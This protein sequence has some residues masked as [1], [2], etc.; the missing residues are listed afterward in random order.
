MESNLKLIL[1]SATTSG[2]VE[3][4]GFE[5]I[6]LKKS[7]A[8][9]TDLSKRK[10]AYTLNFTVGG[11]ENNNKLFNHIFEIGADSTFDSRKKAK[12]WLLQDS[13][14]II[15]GV[16]QLVNISVDAQQKII[17]ELTISDEAKDL[18]LEIGEGYI[19]DLDYSSLAHTLSFSAVTNS[20]T[21]G[22]DYFYPLVDY[23]YDLA[24]NDING[25]NNVSGMTLNK[26]FPA[27]SVK[28]IFD[29]IISET[30]KSIKS[31]FLTG[32][33]FA[34]LFIPFNGDASGNLSEDFITQ[35][36]YKATAPTE[37]LVNYT[38]VT[39]VFFSG[40][41][42]FV[43][44]YSVR[45]PATNDSTGGN[46]DGGGLYDNVN[47]IYTSN[48]YSIQRFTSVG[49][50][51]LQNTGLNGVYFSGSGGNTAQLVGFNWYRSSYGAG[52][53]YP[54]YQSWLTPPSFAN[55]IITQTPFLN[56]AIGSQ[57]GILTPGETVWCDFLYKAAVNKSLITGGT[58]N[59]VRFK[60]NAYI[61]NEMSGQVVVNTPVDMQLFVPKK[62][63]KTD[64]I[65][66][67]VLMFNLI[68]ETDKDN[69]NQLII[70]P[71]HVYYSG[72]TIKNWTNKLDTSK[73]ATVQLVSN[74][75]PKKTVFSYKQDK[76]YLNEFYYESINR[77]YGDYIYNNDN[78]FNNAEKR[79]E[80]IFSP[81]PSDN[82]RG[83]DSVVVPKIYKKENNN[84][85]GRTDHNIRILQKSLPQFSTS[86]DTFIVQGQNAGNFYPCLNHLSHPITGTTDINWGANDYVYWT[87]N[88][89]TENNL[90]NTYWK[91]SL[92]EYNDKDARIVTAYFNLSPSDINQFKFSDSIYVKG[93]TS[94]GGHYFKVNAI[95]YVPTARGSSKVE[96]IKVKETTITASTKTIYKKDAIFLSS[97]RSSLTLGSSQNYGS[98]S[99]AIGDGNIVLSDRSFVLGAD[100]I[101]QNNTEGA[102][103]LGSGNTIA[104][105]I[106]G[107][108]IFGNNISATTTGATYIENLIVT[109]GF[110]FN[111]LPLTSYTDS[112][113]YVT[114]G[115][116][117]Y[118]TIRASNDTSIDSTGSYSVA[119]GNAT[120]STGNSSFAAGFLASATSIASFACGSNNLSSGIGSFAGGVDNKGGANARASFVFG[121]G[122]TISSAGEYSAIL[123]GTGITVTQACLVAVPDFA[124][125]KHLPVP[126][127]SGDTSGTVGQITWNDS[128]MF[129][130]TN[131][132]WGRV[133]IDYGF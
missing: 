46:F 36:T 119:L 89:I 30:G 50:Y 104:S 56:G 62:I 133:A 26:M 124:I 71:S 13:I 85:Y 114:S 39:N 73:K 70:E 5:Q 28:Y 123:G 127:S 96:L 55:N 121:S 17:Y 37:T 9:I 47:F 7:V 109:S 105:G 92:D 44:D 24:F 38:A 117:G 19:E 2:V 68:V 74:T 88:E 103:V 79:I 76:D 67:I 113:E 128:Y 101:L 132:G 18:F 98:G 95:E 16:L 122:H 58:G 54:F 21:G 34:S 43:A 94:D 99:L 110:T 116:S 112:T 72:G 25:T 75:Q 125:K 53:I 15:E 51:E 20:W 118:M 23:S 83:S 11:G 64:F 81:T 66:S 61:Y 82:I 129:I 6:T 65:K 59:L 108:S 4:S 93:L 80:V 52:G 60:P 131:T 40:A 90:V 42:S 63:K 45:V 111:G 100:N 48:T 115:T 97:A 41:N 49:S 22:T 78:D 86:G 87:L 3:L 130:K 29:K 8:D 1:S 57:F 91:K 33:T 120:K 69:A 12:C 102:F 14:S 107:T 106:Y 84:T 32:A 27:I 77:T 10:N 35:R 31:T 126:T